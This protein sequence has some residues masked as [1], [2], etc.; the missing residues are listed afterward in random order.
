MNF[1]RVSVNGVSVRVDNEG[2]YNLNDFH[3]VAMMDE[4]Y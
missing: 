1:P 2:R 3:A 4:S